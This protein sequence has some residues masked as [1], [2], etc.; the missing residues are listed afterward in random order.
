MNIQK[1]LLVLL[2]TCRNKTNTC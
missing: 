1:V 2:F